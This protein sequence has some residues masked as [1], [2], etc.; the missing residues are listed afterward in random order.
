MQSCPKNVL[1][2]PLTGDS[3]RSGI[4]SIAKESVPLPPVASLALPLEPASATGP[5]S[6]ARGSAGMPPPPSPAGA[7]YQSGPKLEAAETVECKPLDKTRKARVGKAMVRNNMAAANNLQQNTMLLMCHPIQS[8][9]IGSV[10]REVE[11]PKEATKEVKRDCLSQENQET[12]ECDGSSCKECN[13]EKTEER[14]QETYQLKTENDESKEVALDAKEIPEQNQ[15]C[16]KTVAETVKVKNMKRK[17]ATVSDI[18]R[19]PEADHTPQKKEKLDRLKTVNGSYKD[20]I[21]KSANY[22]K[23]NNGRRKLNV[24]AIKGTRSRFALCKTSRIKLK[25]SPKRKLNCL[26]VEVMQKRLK[27]SKPLTASSLHNSKQNIKESKKVCANLESG[28]NNEPLKKITKK[29]KLN[30]KTTSVVKKLAPV[31]LDNLL[32]KNNVDRTIDSVIES[33]LRTGKE[34]SALKTSEKCTNCKGYKAL[35]KKG[36]KLKT[37]PTK[38]KVEC[39]SYCPGKRKVRNKNPESTPQIITGVPRKSLQCPRWSNGWTWEG[40]PFEGRVFLNVS[41][42]LF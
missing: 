5:P 23:I 19:E 27:S 26:R 24:D 33:G 41:T 36:T 34:T 3:K 7:T 14:L 18:K 15:P 29:S 6:P 21:K 42:Y 2:G 16:Q 35:N 13:S 30:C 12:V 39:K 1:T 9:Y 20:L 28:E 25:K 31:L 37:E 17:L 11:S 40:E 4:L 8:T 38:T 22:I 10:K 32:A